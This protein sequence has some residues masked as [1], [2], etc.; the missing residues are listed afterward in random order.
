MGR[1]V[2]ASEAMAYIKKNDL[3]TGSWEQNLGRRRSRVRWI[4]KRIAKTFDAA[5]CRGV[6]H[7]IE[8]GQFDNWSRCHA[9]HGI[10]RRDRQMV[11]EFGNIVVKK[12]RGR[13]DWRFVSV[14]LSVA[15]FCLAVDPN[16]DGS[17][18]QARAKELWSRCCSE[19]P[20]C[21]RQMG[22]V[23]GLA[24]ES[25]HYQDSGSEVLAWQGDAV[26]GGGR[27]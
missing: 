9:S 7:E 11:D 17:L 22:S 5:K 25:G 3:F 19:V 24:G 14:F 2:T 6:R 10:K 27:S 13:A 18:P 20:F 15:K 16:D 1:V 21:E 4:L 8:V 23:S 12:R 26:G